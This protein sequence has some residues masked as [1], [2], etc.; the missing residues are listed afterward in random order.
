MRDECVCCIIII[1]SKHELSVCIEEAS[2]INLRDEW[3]C[4][5]E[6]SKINLRDECMYVYRGK[7]RSKINTA[8]VGR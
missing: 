1:I 6:A 4:T 7:L 3:M 2:K 5:E 8:K